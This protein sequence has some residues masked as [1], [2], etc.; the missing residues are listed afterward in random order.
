MFPSSLAPDSRS[1][2]ILFLLLAFASGCNRFTRTKQCRQLIAQVNPALDEIVSITG[3]GGAAGA[4]SSASGGGAS[5]MSGAGGAPAHAGPSGGIYLAAA[6]RYERLAK[7][8]GPME[9]AS[10]DMARSVA[11]YASLLTS[12][13]QILRALA[14]ALDANNYLEAEKTSR[15]LDRLATRERA[16]LNRID[17]WC[18]PGS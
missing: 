17:A 15:D 3:T 10:E 8:L 1:L 7:Q 12:T 2:R 5:G 14:S 4:A 13:A 16:A 18:Q 6:V 9:F 11:E